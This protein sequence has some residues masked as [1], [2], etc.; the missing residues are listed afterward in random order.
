MTRE[1]LETAAKEACA[2]CRD[3]HPTKYWL[4]EFTHTMQK[5]TMITHTLCGANDLRVFYQKDSG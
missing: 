4:G 5:G 1:E 3:G 2:Y